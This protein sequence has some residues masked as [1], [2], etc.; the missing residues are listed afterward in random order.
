MFTAFQA[1]G[2]SGVSL[3]ETWWGDRT[4]TFPDP[5]G[6]TI[7]FW[8]TVE[9]T[10][11]RILELY[12]CGPDH[13]E[14]A[15]EG[16]S[17]VD[18][19]LVRAPGKWSIRQIVHHIVDSDLSSLQRNKMALAEPGRVFNG[20]GYGPDTWAETLDYAGRSVAPAV[21][22]FRAVRTHMLQ[23]LTHLPGAMDRYVEMPAGTRR[24]VSPAVSM[25]ASH[26]LG[27]IE[28]ILETRNVHGK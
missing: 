12:A 16:L 11:E 25:V 23:L 26:A 22:L 10:P 9:R 15:L 17:E 13:L 27:H 2:L 5:D 28:Q 14:K 1:R 18:L 19:G 7:S 6:Y 3:E 8:A 20:N 4:L 21:A 24:P